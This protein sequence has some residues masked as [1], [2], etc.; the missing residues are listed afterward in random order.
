MTTPLPVGLARVKYID[1]HPNLMC[2]RTLLAVLVSISFLLT[3]LSGAVDANLAAEPTG[4]IAAEGNRATF[5]K[6]VDVLIEVKDEKATGAGRYMLFNPSNETE[7]LTICFDSG[8]ISSNVSVNKDGVRV[9]VEQGAI[10]SYLNYYWGEVFDVAV[11]PNTHTNITVDWEFDIIERSG[12]QYTDRT[13]Y[14]AR[15]LIIGTAGWNH[16]IERVNVTFHLDSSHFKS[17]SAN[18]GFKAYTMDVGVALAYEFTDFDLQEEEI[19]VRGDSFIWNI[20]AMSC[21]ILFIVTGIVGVALY[22]G[23]RKREKRD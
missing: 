20:G 7:F 23:I 11:Y 16:S 9:A 13:N 21:I 19:V 10:T 22:L 12:T 18:S 17:Y 6:T 4:G 2:G 1:S 3:A 5:L 8:T 15:Y 14:V